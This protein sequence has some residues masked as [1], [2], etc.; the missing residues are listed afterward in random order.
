MGLWGFG[1]LGDMGL[2]DYGDIE[3]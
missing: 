2:Q 1:A 3:R